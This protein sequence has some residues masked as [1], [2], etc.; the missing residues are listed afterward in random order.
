MV[1]MEAPLLLGAPIRNILWRASAA[2]RGGDRPGGGAEMRGG[3]RPFE[4]ISPSF[5]QP[6]RCDDDGVVGRRGEAFPVW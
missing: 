3:R 5:L 4:R 6:R 1:I 2:L